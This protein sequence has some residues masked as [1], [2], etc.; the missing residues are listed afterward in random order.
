MSGQPPLVFGCLS[1]YIQL[2]SESARWNLV[3]CR[4]T[5][6]SLR[7]LLAEEGRGRK[8][9]LSPFVEAAVQARTSEMTVERP[10]RENAHLFSDEISRIVDEAAVEWARRG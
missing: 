4:N 8:G 9:E 3:V 10:K 5:D 1:A 7:L 2:M 6:R